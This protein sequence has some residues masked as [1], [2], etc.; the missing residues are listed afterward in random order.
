MADKPTNV[1]VLE[2]ISSELGNNLSSLSIP[3]DANF[4]VQF[5]NKETI[6]TSI[7]ELT[8]ENSIEPRKWADSRNKS[9]EANTF[10]TSNQGDYGILFA[11]KVNI[12]GESLGVQRVGIKESTTGILLGA[13]VLNNRSQDTKLKIDFIETN[14]SFPDFVIRPWVLAA[15]HYGLFARANG[16][17]HNVKRTLLITWLDY[18]KTPRK[19]FE[20]YDCVPVSLTGTDYS[21]SESSGVRTVSTEW[22][23]KNYTL[24]S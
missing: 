17:P 18:N 24:N 16:S 21:Y 1:N 23:Y 10:A 3:V 13:T 11:S 14:N 22:I 7:F 2:R 9:I 4:I 15:S 20:F 8:G 6:P 12:P 5:S 19:I